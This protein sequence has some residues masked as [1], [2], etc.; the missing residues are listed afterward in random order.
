MIFELRTAEAAALLPPD[1][2]GSLAR[3]GVPI[4]ATLRLAVAYDL[5]VIHESTGKYDCSWQQYNLRFQAEF[6]DRLKGI[7]NAYRAAGLNVKLQ[8]LEQ[9]QRLR[10]ALAHFRFPM[11]E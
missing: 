11:F 9:V 6:H 10:A 7:P 1:S 2:E 5:L 3:R 8:Q 4:P